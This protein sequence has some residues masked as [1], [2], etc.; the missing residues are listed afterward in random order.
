LEILFEQGRELFDNEQFEEA[1]LT[2]EAALQL[3]Q[4]LQDQRQEAHAYQNLGSSYYCL[5]NFGCLYA[6]KLSNF[7][8]KQKKEPER[9]RASERARERSEKLTCFSTEK[10]RCWSCIKKLLQSTNNCLTMQDFQ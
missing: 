6:T 9:E 5:E 2:Y 1:I 10:Q 7:S 4:K 3:A 8:T